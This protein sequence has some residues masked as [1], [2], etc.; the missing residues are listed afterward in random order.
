M[1][2]YHLYDETQAYNRA[3]SYLDTIETNYPEF[4]LSI[5]ILESKAVSLDYLIEPRDTSK[6]RVAYE[7]LLQFP[8]LSSDKQKMYKDRLSN[9]DKGFEDIIP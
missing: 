9:L 5:P 3:I 6:I 2:I 4:A 7:R 1:N 8:N